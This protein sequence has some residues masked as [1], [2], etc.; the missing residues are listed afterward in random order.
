MEGICKCGCKEERQYIRPLL[1][2]KLYYYYYYFGFLF[3]EIG[4]GQEEEDAL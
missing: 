2:L 1:D 3:N 4:F